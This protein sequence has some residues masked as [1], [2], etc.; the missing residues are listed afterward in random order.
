MDYMGIKIV[1]SDAVKDNEI[2]AVPAPREYEPPA[3]YLERMKRE[4]FM[5]RLTPAG[6]EGRE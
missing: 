4:A 6:R 1:A 5:V 3:E 2:M